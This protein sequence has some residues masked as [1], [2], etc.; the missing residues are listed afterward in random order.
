MSNHPIPKQPLIQRVTSVEMCKR[1]NEGGYW[2]RVK[3]GELTAHLLDEC[4]SSLLSHEPGPI[5]SQS[6]SYRD[7]NGNEVARVHQFLR[8]DD[9]IAASGLPDP[10]RLLE[11]GVLYRLEKKQKPKVTPST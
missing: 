10:K 6:V 1:F 5:R 9:S 11:G 3:R 2:N 4:I 7:L 8:P